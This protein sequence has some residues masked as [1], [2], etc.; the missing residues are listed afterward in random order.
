MRYK[1]I[2]CYWLSLWKI[3]IAVIYISVKVHNN[4][5]IDLKKSFSKTLHQRYMVFKAI[6]SS[7]FFSNGLVSRMF[8]TKKIK[9][10][11]KKKFGPIV[12]FRWQ[13]LENI[14]D[15]D[16]RIKLISYYC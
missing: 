13:R 12:Y 1:Y 6:Y 2:K 10:V 15:W 7:I 4:T 9:H 5:A 14:W 11:F 16:I 8:F 3:F